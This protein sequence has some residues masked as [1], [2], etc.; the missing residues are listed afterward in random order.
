MFLHPIAWPEGARCAASVTFDIDADSLIRTACPEDAELRLQPISMGRYGPT[1]AVPRI[2]E[3][4]RRWGL[5]QTFFMPAWVMR[6]YPETVETIL[7]D[8]HE[9][10][11][12]SWCHEDPMAHSDDREAELFESALEVH[13]AMTGRKPRGYRAPVYSLT[14]QMVDR[15]IAHDFL[16]DSSMMADDLPYLVETSGGSLIEL[17]P[18]WGTDDWPPFAHFSEIDYLMPVRAPSN[19][20]RAFA[21]EFDAMHAAGGFW[22]PV[23]HPFLTGRVARWCEMEKLIERALAAGDVWFAPLEE[24][25]GHATS[26]RA[27]LRRE[28]LDK[29]VPP[30]A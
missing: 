20:I 12:H 6:A 13:V 3:S 21:E 27:E 22:M 30:R 15:L 9:I 10:G 5:R 19:G 29:P 17:P 8:G 2:L 4:Y 18:H 28:R 16:Y 23:L 11:H 26:V 25:A 1:V 24:I 14:P 7:K